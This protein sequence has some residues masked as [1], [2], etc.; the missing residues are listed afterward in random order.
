M[1][2]DELN[3][4][5][6]IVDNSMA[7]SDDGSFCGVGHVKMMRLRAHVSRIHHGSPSTSLIIK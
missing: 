1:T 4:L 7:M 5:D 3:W 6:L 2:G